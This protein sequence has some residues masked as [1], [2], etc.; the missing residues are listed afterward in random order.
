VFTSPEVSVG[1]EE[2]SPGGEL[3]LAGDEEGKV[4]VSSDVAFEIG[5]EVVVLEPGGSVVLGDP[6]VE[7]IGPAVTGNDDVVVPAPVL[8]LVDVLVASLS[9]DG[10][11][12][13]VWPQP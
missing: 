8:L 5:A 6:V 4:A 2:T 10:P 13:D 11:E 9:M 7:L 1:S 12:S 3:V